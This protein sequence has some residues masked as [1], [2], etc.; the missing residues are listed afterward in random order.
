MFFQKTIN[1]TVLIH[2]PSDSSE[3]EKSLKVSLICLT[4][5]FK[6]IH[7]LLK[8]LVDN[9]FHL[10]WEQNPS[11]LQLKKVWLESTLG[12]FLSQESVT[13]STWDFSLFYFV[14]VLFWFRVLFFYSAL[15]L[16]HIVLNIS[17]KSLFLIKNT[18]I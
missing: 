5:F 6:Y 2:S 11:W 7:N 8:W 12:T 1:L 10:F 9:T 14:F 16:S 3:K 17:N 13:S 18:S 4:I 15:T